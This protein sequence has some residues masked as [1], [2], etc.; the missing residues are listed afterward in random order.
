MSDV[1]SGLENVFNP[2]LALA[3]DRIDSS[4]AAVHA[5]VEPVSDVSDVSDRLETGLQAR[6]GQAI[7]PAR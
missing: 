4:E 1:C 6:L 5:L 3:P 7:P 2:A